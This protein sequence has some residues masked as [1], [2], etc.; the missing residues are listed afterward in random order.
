M[1]AIDARID[2][3]IIRVRI[4]YKAH[5]KTHKLLHLTDVIPNNIGVF[6]MSKP[7]RGRRL[8]QQGREACRNQKLRAGI[9]E[10]ILHRN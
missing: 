2:A 6:R 10:N 5:R 8:D 3:F 1:S 9:Y 7:F 4:D